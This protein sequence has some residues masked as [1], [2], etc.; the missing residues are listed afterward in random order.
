MTITN[1]KSFLS[2]AAKGSDHAT[3]ELNLP[4]GNKIDSSP[5][6]D[7]NGAAPHGPFPHMPST[8]AN[9]WKVGLT[10]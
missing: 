3:A 1:V 8:Y 2:L 9:D 4:R 5:K 10:Y 7:W 6:M